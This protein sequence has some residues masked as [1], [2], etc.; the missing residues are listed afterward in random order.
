MGNA[1]PKPNTNLAVRLRNIRLTYDGCFVLLCCPLKANDS[2]PG[3]EWWQTGNRF[4]TVSHHLPPMP[5]S[6]VHQVSLVWTH[7]HVPLLLWTLVSQ[8][9]LLVANLI[10][11]LRFVSF[12]QISANAYSIHLSAC[13]V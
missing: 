3:H 6:V 8:S 7:A 1:W 11:P 12:D 9:R 2:L 4:Y 10:I 13:S 5:L